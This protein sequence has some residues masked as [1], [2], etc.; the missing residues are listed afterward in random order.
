VTLPESRIGEIAFAVYNTSD[1]ELVGRAE[2]S[3][4]APE[5]APEH[6]WFSIDGE[7]ERAFPPDGAEHYLVRIVVPDTV[8]AANYVF[9]LD[10]VGV[11]NPDEG[12]VAGPSA[13]VVV[14]PPKEN[15]KGF[16]WWILAVVGG[17]VLVVGIA[18][19]I[20]FWPD[21]EEEGVV[22]PEVAGLTSADAQATLTNLCAP[23]S[24][25]SCIEVIVEEL[26]VP[27]GLVVRSDPSSGDRAVPGSSVT[28]FIPA[29]P[30]IP[31]VFGLDEERARS[32]LRNACPQPDPCFD[33]QV[34][35]V[36][37]VRGV[38]TVR[39]SDP[40][41]GHGAEPGTVVTIFI[42]VRVLGP[43]VIETIPP[44]LETDP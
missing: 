42:G 20:F 15:G 9:R 1:T 38:G 31:N 30:A 33:A 24:S 22:I 4:D 39:G 36:L 3:V 29:V 32:A 41:A 8:P 35:K 44:I 5:G 6:G 21:D 10:M 26:G 40:P 17:V 18:A 7:P 11:A 43:D 12:Y 34:Q 2:I 23:E 16:P 28:I 13:T 19:A 25:D 27:T 14:P 37:T